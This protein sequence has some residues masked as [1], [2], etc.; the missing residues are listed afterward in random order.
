[1]PGV[2]SS[3]FELGGDS[4]KAVRIFARLE[5]RLGLALSLAQIFLTPTIEE[6]A[7]EIY[8]EIERTV[9]NPDAEQAVK[10]QGASPA[11]V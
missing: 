8:R 10:A 5:R 7:N 6:L 11:S 1:V 9:R 4:L 3:F 2:R